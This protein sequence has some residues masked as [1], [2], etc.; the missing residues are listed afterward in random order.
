MLCTRPGDAR[1][2]VG[3]YTC[4]QWTRTLSNHA[5]KCRDSVGISPSCSTQIKHH[6]FQLLWPPYTRFYV[7]HPVA[8]HICAC[9]VWTFSVR[10]VC[11]H[12]S[13]A[14]L[15][16]LTIV[17]AVSSPV[18]RLHSHSREFVSEY[19]STKLLLSYRMFAL[20]NAPCCTTRYEL[21]QASKL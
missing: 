9:G 17:C 6:L 3:F 13:C 20:S 19:C 21:S 10:A 1:V 11:R 8:M 16:S 5:R 18:L 14:A 4:R 15:W 12:E 7:V 2:Y